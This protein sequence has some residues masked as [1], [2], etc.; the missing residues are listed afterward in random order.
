MSRA[1]HIIR[2]RGPWQCEAVDTAGKVAASA[3]VDMPGSWRQALPPESRAVRLL[4]R[5]NC[6]T[7]LR[8]ERVE[9]VIECCSQP[10]RVAL[11]GTWLTDQFLSDFPL[12]FVVATLLIPHNELVI[13]TAGTE[14]GLV[15]L[16]IGDP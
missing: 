8:S 6:P 9:I 3:T 15:M 14:L 7:G 16:V 12:R 13:E 11:N 2:L 1:T 4:R 5:F 10:I